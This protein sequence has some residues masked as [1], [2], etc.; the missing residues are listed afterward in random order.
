V[1]IIRRPVM[2]YHGGKFRIAP[3]MIALFPEHRRYVE[4]YGGGAGILLR[5]PQVAVEV[6]NDLDGEVVNV[7]RVLRDPRRARR[8]QLAA[9]LT[10]FARAE[11]ELSYE[12]HAD[13]VE[14]ARRT[15][16]RSFMAFGTTHR[17]SGHTGF[18]ATGMRRNGTTAKDWR[19]WPGHIPAFVD[20]LRDIII[21]RRPA[22]EVIK[23]QDGP[24]T[25]FFLDPPYVRATRTFM[26]NARR[27][28]GAY[29]FDMDD[30]DHRAL[31]SALCSIEGMAIICGYKH[32]LYDREL[33]PDWH[34]IELK[35]VADGAKPRIEVLWFNDR[36]SAH[37]RRPARRV[38]A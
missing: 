14:Q 22:L 19:T 24:D 26:T 23:Q 1:S 28:S 27:R 3:R 11:F 5:K 8:L 33:Y 16:A 37:L 17:R 34:R 15:I 30:D 29:T 10:P 9:E 20:R 12:P 36:A 6:Y 31:A 32:P 18:R 2:R 25:L 35:T 13:P 21:E 38:A 4:P 7:F